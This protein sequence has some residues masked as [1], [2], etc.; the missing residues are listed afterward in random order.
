M[1]GGFFAR[2]QYSSLGEGAENVSLG[3]VHMEEGVQIRVQVECGGEEQGDSEKH[4][5]R[6]NENRQSTAHH[7]WHE[8]GMSARLQTLEPWL[9]L[10]QA[11]NMHNIRRVQCA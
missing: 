5:E 11:V 8:G 7:G 10:T 6:Q 4:R 2:V 3:A 1:G 9:V